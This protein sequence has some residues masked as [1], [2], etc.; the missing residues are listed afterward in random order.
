MARRNKPAFAQCTLTFRPFARPDAGGKVHGA[1]KAESGSFFVHSTQNRMTGSNPSI[2]HLIAGFAYGP[3]RWE[4][5]GGVAGRAA[6][7]KL[8]WLPTG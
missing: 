4:S 2:S 5:R 3:R 7:A 6:W 1:V 8:D